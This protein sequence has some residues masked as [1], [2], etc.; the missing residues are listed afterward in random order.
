LEGLPEILTAEVLTKN[1]FFTMEDFEKLPDDGNNYELI[2]G[3]LD[4]KNA[5]IPDVAFI[6]SG[7]SVNI[8]ELKGFPGAPDLAIEVISPSDTT[9]RIHNKIT[10]Y[11]RFGVRL[12]WS[13][14]ILD[15]YVLVYN[16]DDPDVKL[17]NLKDELDGGDVAPKFNLNVGK[18]F[19]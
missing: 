7:R 18:L 3:E 19:E 16:L 2:K 17:L 1:D 15:K 6:Q 14:Y 13:I 11:R 5:P 10:L 8:D 12:V 9:E 4:R